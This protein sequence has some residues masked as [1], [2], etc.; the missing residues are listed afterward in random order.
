MNSVGLVAGALTMAMAL[1]VRAAVGAGRRSSLI[2]RLP[3]RTVA[4]GEGGARLRLPDPPPALARRLDS[5]GLTLDARQ[6]W[7]GW[8]ATLVLAVS[9]GMTLGGP[10][11]AV[12]AVV[13]VVAGPMLALLAAAGR[14]DHLVEDALP[15][16]LESMARALR[17]GASLRQAV[18]ETA[19]VTPGLL[20][21]DLA[22]VAAEVVHGRLLAA[23]LDRWGR[24]R[25]LPGVRLAVSAL[26]LGAETGGA[27]ARAIDGVAA[28]VRS[29]S[30]VGREVRALS[31]QARLSAV[32]ITLAPLGFSALAAA[33]DERTAGFLLRTPLGLFCLVAGLAL[34]A[35]A[36]LWM[37]RLSRVES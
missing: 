16:A 32:V 26:A 24:R 29:R 14:A 36:A 20:G 37:L 13:M 21:R 7:A 28:T 19:G 8:I 5:T 18:E 35:V 9:V 30:A 11:L 22:V 15:D 10:G 27:H 25:P 23:A 1:I 17:S 34:D 4:A 12:V 2:H 3:Q 6:V 33:S 31:S